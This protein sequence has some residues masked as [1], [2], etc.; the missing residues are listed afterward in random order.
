MYVSASDLRQAYESKTTSELLELG[1]RGTLTSVAQGVVEQMLRERGVSKEQQQRAL[2]AAQQK[3]AEQKREM[4]KA[5]LGQRLI[6]KI[7][8]MAIVL[9]LFVSG[10]ASSKMGFEM[11][12]PV[13]LLLALAYLWLADGLPKGQSLGKKCFGIAVVH[14][15]T[16]RPCHYGQ[17]F[18]RNILLT[19]LEILD[20]IFM[21]VDT[22]QRLGDIVARTIVIKLSP[23]P[24]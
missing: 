3:M 12:H 6:A 16:G 9:C 24:A 19:I 8:D 20:L 1:T 5:P 14:E 11:G 22:R 17:S 15:K 2:R 21:L 18:V 10:I 13:G 4:E 7:I 23:A